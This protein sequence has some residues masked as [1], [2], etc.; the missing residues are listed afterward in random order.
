[1]FSLFH[2]G[3]VNPHQIPEQY[4]FMS[5]TVQKKKHKNKKSKQKSGDIPLH[6]S[7]IDS[8]SEMVSGREHEKKHKKQRRHDEEKERRKKKKDKKK[9]KQRHSPEPTN[10]SMVMTNDGAL[11]GGSANSPMLSSG[12]LTS[13][14]NS[15]NGL[16][17]A[18]SS[19]INPSTNALNGS[20][21]G[22]PL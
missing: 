4:R 19:G 5:Q 22:R 21:G 14:L 3:F 6:D 9:K 11:S 10:S 18:L 17:G 20:L 2:N 16:S 1:M 8:N 12:S 15:S 7:H 13:L